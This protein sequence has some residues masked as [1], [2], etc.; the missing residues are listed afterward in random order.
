MKFF[1]PRNRIAIGLTGAVV[2]II[3]LAKL[4]GYIPDQNAMTAS[5]RSSL[6]ETIA[7]GGSALIDRGDVDGLMSFMEG[8][9]ARNGDVQSIGVIRSSGAYVIKTGAHGQNW[10]PMKN[11]ELSSESQVQ[12]PIINGV[13]E[14]WG[15]IQIS[16]CDHS[17]SLVG[18]INRAGIPLLLFIGSSCFLIFNFVLFL[19]LKQLDPAKAV[20]QQVR[21]A[22]D[23]LAEGLLILDTQ[24]NILLANSS[25]SKVLG[26][27]SNKLIGQKTKRLGIET[28]GTPPW[29]SALAE[30]KL[31]SNERVV[32]T[33]CDGKERR[34]LVNCS[35]LLG[36]KGN[37]CGVMVTFDD[38]TQ[39]EES[40]NQLQVA[41]DEADAANQAK[42]DF[43][44]NMSHEIRTPM[45]AILGFAD[46]LRRGM[47]ETPEQRMEYLNTI[48]SNGSHLI[49]LINEIL[50]LSKVE[51]GKLELEMR[52]FALPELVHGVVQVLSSKAQQ[53]D[54]GLNYEV[55]GSI[56]S[57][58]TSDSTRIRQILINLVGNAVK[59]TEIGNVVL[60]C[61][62]H[63]G[64]IRFDI[65]DSGI[66]M[67]DEQMAKIFDP[68][69]QA[70]S[71]VTRRFGGT[72][73]GLSICKKFAEALEGS[74]SVASEPGVGTTFTVNLPV[75]AKTAEFL[76]HQQCVNH[77]QSALQHETKSENRKLNRSTVLVVDDGPTN[78]HMV[79]VVLKRHGL[80]IIEAEN[81]QIACDIVQQT[82]VDIVLMDMQMPVMDG[83]TATRTIREM[84]HDMPIVALTGNAT[85]EDELKSRQAGCNSLLPKP[86][87]IDQLIE[88]LGQ[89]VGF[90]DEIL[91]VASKAQPKAEPVPAP[92]AENAVS[93]SE[94]VEEEA[95]TN[96]TQGPEAWTSTLPMEDEEFYR[97]VAS[98]V[99]SLSPRLDGMMTM[100][101]NSDMSG[102][103]DEAHWL[104]GAAGTVGLGRL[105][106]P[107]AQ[108]EIYS[109]EGDVSK[110]KQALIEIVEL[111]GAI[112]LTQPNGTEVPA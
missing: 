85:E 82:D 50:D 36:H 41:R 11:D 58:I 18:M 47:E 55:V 43:L 51:A 3:C 83:Y 17:Q 23:N 81:G 94:S 102:L 38:V 13:E 103:V 70:D 105:T 54:V 1:S 65:V 61:K 21:D 106:E 86:I 66:G 16:F 104:K 109:K 19:V 8:V 71:S 67:T 110:C 64:Q 111:A 29:E 74:I 97:I 28:E 69:S 15:T 48:H 60:S 53:K 34:Y 63:D 88:T 76:D 46:V 37:Y 25:F 56:P 32:L 4:A 27:D 89:S 112:S 39:L 26:K 31:V 107:S 78:R 22:L 80:E 7:L 68:F 62:Y 92:I 42:S 49:E 33:D 73:L 99:D 59:F 79:S 10:E 14:K 93:N 9:A 101:E 12:V 52:E 75:E 20:P 96:S 44:A 5:S 90:S 87:D 108:L 45:N 77:I 6:S 91:V 100:L 95:A 72:G 57:M 84:G 24:Y 2:L 30:K 35:P 40:R 98:F